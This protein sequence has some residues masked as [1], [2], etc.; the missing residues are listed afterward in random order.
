MS[1]IKLRFD[2]LEY[3][4]L[5]QRISYALVVNYYRFNYKINPHNFPNN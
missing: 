5:C 1:V 4:T 3:G 2:L